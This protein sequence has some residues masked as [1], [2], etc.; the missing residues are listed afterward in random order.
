[1]PSTSGSGRRAAQSAASPMDN[2]QEERDKC[3]TKVQARD[4][5]EFGMIPVSCAEIRD[6]Y[7]VLN[8]PFILTGIRWTLS[9]YCSLPQFEREHVGADSNRASEC[10]S[11]A[12]QSIAG[13]GRGGSFVHRGSC[14]INSYFSHGE[15]YW[16]TWIKIYYGR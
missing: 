12:I 2:D 7:N 4:L 1:M 13:I 6:Y 3:L 10:S 15:A 14:G 5:V 16:C 9:S 11:S 8:I